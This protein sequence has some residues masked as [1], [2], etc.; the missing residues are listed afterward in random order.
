MGGLTAFLTVSPVPSEGVE[1]SSHANLSQ[2]LGQSL[3][4]IKHRG[5]DAQGQWISDDGLVGELSVSFFR[6]K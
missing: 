2:A 6:V 4:I 5:P 1:P 3:D